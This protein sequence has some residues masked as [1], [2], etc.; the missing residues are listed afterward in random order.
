[1]S[2]SSALILWVLSVFAA[3]GFGW[4]TGVSNAA[5]VAQGGANFMVWLIVIAFVSIAGSVAYYGLRHRDHR[6]DARTPN[7][8]LMH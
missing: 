6:D 8:P 1:M 4:Y 7:D 3:Y 5:R 2:R